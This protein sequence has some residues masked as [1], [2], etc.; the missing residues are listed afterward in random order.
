M[1][2]LKY[3]LRLN[4]PPDGSK[5]HKSESTGLFV[6]SQRDAQIQEYG[7]HFCQPKAYL[8]ETH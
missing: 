3:I 7:V 1:W 5:S 8:D 4:G 2:K 6:V